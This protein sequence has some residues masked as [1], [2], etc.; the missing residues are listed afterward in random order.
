MDERE[1]ADVDAEQGELELDLHVVLERYALPALEPEIVAA[2]YRTRRALRRPVVSRFRLDQKRLVKPDLDTMGGFGRVRR[3]RNLRVI[4]GV[5]VTD[6]TVLV[7]LRVMPKN[8]V[9]KVLRVSARE[10]IGSAVVNVG[11]GGVVVDVGANE[12]LDRFLFEVMAHF[13][14]QPGGIALNAVGLLLPDRDGG[15]AVSRE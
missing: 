6:H 8:R 10:L 11:F 5:G 9:L 7:V 4:N 12:Q 14:R 1:I 3:E 13:R 2:D 15:P